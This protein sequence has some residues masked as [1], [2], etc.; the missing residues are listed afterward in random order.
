MRYLNGYVVEETLISS[1]FDADLQR[2][3]AEL[4]TSSFYGAEEGEAEEA[5]ELL[6]HM[7]EDL[8]ETD[9]LNAQFANIQDPHLRDPLLYKQNE[10]LK[11]MRETLVERIA[12]Q[13][14]QSLPFSND[15]SPTEQT[16][17]IEFLEAT[18]TQAQS[19]QEDM[20]RV[21]RQQA[22]LVVGTLQS[23]VSSVNI[24]IIVLFVVLAA[25]MVG[26]LWLTQRHFVQPLKQL[27]VA[28]S[29]VTNGQFDQQVPVTNRD[30][31]GMLQDNF[32]AMV[33]SLRAQQYQLKLQQNTLEQQNEALQRERAALQQAMHEIEQGAHE[34]VALQQQ[35]IAA[36][37]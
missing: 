4:A 16:T 22:D 24:T 33:A 1:H 13:A 18:E 10:A 20:L 6:E 25:A 29:A 26:T 36:Q 14:A 28:A 2:L 12:V 8:A 31:I 23:E 30:E 35:V 34:R 27:A 5:L 11:E 17:L 3:L 32:N 37:Q 19:L 15:L 7:R 9:M 21:T